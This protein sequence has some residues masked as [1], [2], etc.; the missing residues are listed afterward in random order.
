MTAAVLIDGGANG[1]RKARQAQ[2]RV[3]SNMAKLTNQLAWHK[4]DRNITAM[5][6]ALA[7]TTEARRSGGVA[8]CRDKNHAVACHVLQALLLL[9]TKHASI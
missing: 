6:G 8:R 1:H 3:S 2:L 4:I 7:V 5:S 9:T